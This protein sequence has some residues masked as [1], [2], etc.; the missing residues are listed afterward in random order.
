GVAL[1]GAL[2]LGLLLTL[3]LDYLD[4]TWKLPDEAE[5]SLDQP[6]LGVVMSIPTPS[7]VAT[8]DQLREVARA[9]HLVSNPRG[10]I[11][12]QCHSVTTNLFSL[13]LE[14]QPRALMVVSASGEDGKT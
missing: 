8:D 12:E 1:A 11:A 10:V 3:L 13:F 4:D 5:R 2:L 7:N 9:E 6:V 14:R